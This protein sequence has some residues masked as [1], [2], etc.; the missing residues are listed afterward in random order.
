MKRTRSLALHLVLLEVRVSPVLYLLPGEAFL[1]VSC[2]ACLSL[3][4]FLTGDNQ[5]SQLEHSFDLH[6]AMRVPICQR[7]SAC[8]TNKPQCSNIC[9]SIKMTWVNTFNWVFEMDGVFT[10]KALSNTELCDRQGNDMSS[11]KWV[12]E[13]CSF[14]LAEAKEG[15][16]RTF[17]NTQHAVQKQHN[18]L[19]CYVGKRATWIS[20]YLLKMWKTRLRWSTW[21]HVKISEVVKEGQTIESKRMH[22]LGV[23][24]HIKSKHWCIPNDNR[25]AVVWVD[26]PW[27]RRMKGKVD[28]E[29]YRGRERN[30]E[31]RKK[32]RKT[33]PERRREMAEGECKNSEAV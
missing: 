16:H 29:R 24:S 28:E 21:V 22:K 7:E 32:G 2:C 6:S 11:D 20:L 10:C 26:Q 17:Q 1:N 23:A 33:V 18:N 27:Q 9:C 8:M 15:H 5:H 3:P 13:Q 12:R 19:P 31:K 4:F 25:Y 14:H 30:R